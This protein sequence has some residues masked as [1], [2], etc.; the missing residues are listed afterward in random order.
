MENLLTE[1]Q[2]LMSATGTPQVF[3][4]TQTGNSQCTTTVTNGTLIKGETHHVTVAY[5]EAML[6]AISARTETIETGSTALPTSDDE[7]ITTNWLKSEYITEGLAAIKPLHASKPL[8]LK[9][10]RVTDLKSNL[11]R[12]LVTNLQGKEGAGGEMSD[13]KDTE[14]VYKLINSLYGADDSNF[15]DNFINSLKNKPVKYKKDGEEQTTD[16]GKL[17]TNPDLELALSYLEDM[18]TFRKVAEAAERKDVAKKTETEEK[19]EEKKDGDKVTA[20]DCKAT[21]EGKCDTTKCDWNK[22][23]NECNVK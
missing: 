9:T 13:S 21:E 1:P 11:D 8:D 4:T 15:A 3:D 22:D 7:K 19:T 12:R 17:A 5:T 23:K 2:F 18:K 10:L 20:T 16:I 6:K 14:A